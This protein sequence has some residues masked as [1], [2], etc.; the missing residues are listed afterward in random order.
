MYE[1]NDRKLRWS[2]YHALKMNGSRR[3]FLLEKILSTDLARFLDAAW[4]QHL[5]IGRVT[6]F[7][8]LS[9]Y[10]LL[11]NFPFSMVI[12]EVIAGCMRTQNTIWLTLSP[13][14]NFLGQEICFVEMVFRHFD[15]TQALTWMVHLSLAF[16]KES[17]NVSR[18]YRKCIIWG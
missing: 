6:I 15:Q 7:A 3:F 4:F 10:F 18:W 2:S 9:S 14:E 12:V 5:T 16:P 1:R 17:W 8:I 13:Q 11:R